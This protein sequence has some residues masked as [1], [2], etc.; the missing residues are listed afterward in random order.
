MAGLIGE[1]PEN[2]SFQR[3]NHY[4]MDAFSLTIGVSIEG[5]LMTKSGFPRQVQGLWG[6]LAVE[7]VS[8]LQE[9][10]TYVFIRGNT[11]VKRWEGARKG[12]ESFQ[13]AIQ[14]CPGEGERKRSESILVFLQSKI[15]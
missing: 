5:F 2:T 1:V 7:L 3:K 12:W 10:D 4:W 8:V 11:C 9:A 13:T 14:V 6:L 15:D